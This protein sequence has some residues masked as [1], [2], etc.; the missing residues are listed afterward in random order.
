MKIKSSPSRKVFEVINYIFL[1][2][3]I[4][5]SLFPLVHILALSLSSNAA[6]L[7]SEKQNLSTLNGAT[8]LRRT[9]S[10]SKIGMVQL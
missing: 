5:I 8:L 4:G 9:L 1:T 10:H 6:A 7:P 2:I 3:I